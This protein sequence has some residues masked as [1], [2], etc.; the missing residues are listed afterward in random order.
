[1]MMIML[2]QFLFSSF[3][4]FFA[5][6]ESLTQINR[7][8]NAAKSSIPAVV[9]IKVKFRQIPGN[10]VMICKPEPKPY[11]DGFNDLKRGNQNVLF[12]SRWYDVTSLHATITLSSATDGHEHSRPVYCRCREISAHH[13]SP[14]RR[15]PLAASASTDTN[16]IRSLLPPSTVSVVL[17]QYTSSTSAGQL[18]TSLVGHTSVLLNAATCWFLAPELSSADGV[19]QL[20][21]RPSGTLFRHTC[22]RRRQFRVGLKS[23]LFADAY[24]WSSENIRYK[25]VMYLLTYLLFLFLWLSTL[26][27]D[28]GWMFRNTATAAVLVT[29]AQIRVTS[30]VLRYRECVMSLPAIHGNWSCSFSFASSRWSSSSAVKCSTSP[31]YWGEYRIVLID[32]PPFVEKLI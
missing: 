10:A 12:V 21:H 7:Q 9:K 3:F 2:H 29:W 27:Y 20:L 16:Y 19:F 23:H 14:P 22:A 4:I 13:S 6:T 1:M 11:V 28:F 30:A 26:H 31:P 25:S 17:T 5:R 8:T 32:Y 24:F 18:L 15:A